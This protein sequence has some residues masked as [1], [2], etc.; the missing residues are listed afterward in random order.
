MDDNIMYQALTARDNRFDG[1]F[2]VGVT[3][4]GIYCRPICS[5]RTPNKDN[6]RFFRHAAAAEKEF[7]RPCL[8]CRPELAPGYTPLEAGQR[9]AHRLAQSI[10]ETPINK[11]IPVEQL[12]K[13]LQTSVRQLRRIAIKEFGVP[14][15]KLAQTQR[16]LLAKQLLTETI[17]P[18]TDI[19][20]AS[21]FSSVRRFNTLFKQHYHLT[22]TSLR[23][24]IAPPVADGFQLP[25]AYRPPLAWSALL[26]F[27]AG[28]AI[29]G[30]ESVTEQYYARTLEF[31]GKQGWIKISPASSRGHYLNLELSVSF[32]PVLSKLLDQVRHFLDLCARPDVID[33]HLR[34]SS[35][36]VPLLDCYPGLRVPGTMNP[37]ELGWRAILGQQISVAA[38]RTL[39]NRFAQQFGAA[40]STPFDQLSLLSPTPTIIA[41]STP[42]QFQKLGIL[43]S[44]ALAII[45]LAKQWP[46]LLGYLHA[47]DQEKFRHHLQSI[48]GIGPWT[49]Q[50]MIMRAFG[51][52][53]AFM[54]TDLGLRQATHKSA[55]ELQIMAESWRPWRSYAAMYLWQS[56]ARK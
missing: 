27:L 21:G 4:T 34:Q 54:A 41:E 1:L 7:F 28:R 53:D 24:T 40:L 39:A 31:S 56:L 35:L 19:A 18:I 23:K 47:E 50:Y 49:S 44:K 55:K 46:I 16:L 17:L 33:Q 5:A 30:V 43:S 8:R 32:L 45:N 51:W 15:I 3:T 37:F 25:L 48:K 20:F 12:A 42:Q 9:M 14:P 13:Q 36:F 22:P 6:C 52:P 2:F 26:E 11:D 29:K 38:A 10:Q